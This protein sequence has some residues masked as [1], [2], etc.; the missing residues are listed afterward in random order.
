MKSLSYLI[1]QI[2]ILLYSFSNLCAQRPITNIAGFLELYDDMDTTSIFIGLG[3]GHNTNATPRHN[4]TM[5]GTSA[6][7]S[8]ISGKENTFVGFEAG[9]QNNS[10]SNNSFFGAHAG[11]SNTFGSE[12]SLFGTYSGT[13]LTTGRSNSFFG[14]YSGR[15]NNEGGQNS[16]FGSLA[17]Q[18]NT[19]G[20]NNSFFGRSAGASNSSGDANVFLGAFSGFS[21]SNG[22]D[23]VFI[24]NATGY[25]NIGGKEN[26]FVGTS[27]GFSLLGDQNTILGAKAGS[28]L[29]NGSKNIFIGHLSGPLSSVV[30]LSHRLFVDIQRTNT[31]LIYG[32]FDNDLIAI[33]G[34]LDVTDGINSSSNS[35]HLKN[36]EQFN[37]KGII[38]SEYTE[39][40]FGLILESQID[41]SNKKL[42]F[43]EFLGLP[44]NVMTLN[45]NGT[46]GIGI[47]DPEVPLHIDGGVDATISSGGYMILGRSESLNTV[48]D[49][50][51]IMARDNGTNAPLNLNINGGDV[52][53]GGK[54]RILDDTTPA[55][56][57]QIRF[58]S[59]TNDF[60]GYDGSKWISLSNK[61]EQTIFLGPGL[62]YSDDEDTSQALGFNLFNGVTS[63]DGL[64]SS[65]KRRIIPINLPVG[66]TIKQI[67]YF[68]KEDLTDMSLNMKLVKFDLTDTNKSN[69]G[70]EFDTEVDNTF[71]GWSSANEFGTEVIEANYFYAVQFYSSGT[72]SVDHEDL[73]QYKGIRV[74]YTLP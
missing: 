57:G 67:A 28:L 26:T 31:P 72:S 11:K 69:A 43:R 66:S 10:A 65:A 49:N 25:N 38:W 42:H 23:N 63:N 8:N 40:N 45:S 41:V 9:L 39:P 1:L 34:T 47:E 50:N 5:I 29:L 4:N 59:S 17:G 64:G 56:S 58:N 70:F 60:E 2:F 20:D 27:A 44:E 35:I 3:A 36:L 18:G 16:F 68:F 14:A 30:E 22:P 48:L 15:E 62:I 52:R 24:G 54:I 61:K 7:H 37:N 21:N 71:F 51:E 19:V 6:G 33:N 32:E 46:V 73:L 55:E 13:E 53:L 74:V 12:N